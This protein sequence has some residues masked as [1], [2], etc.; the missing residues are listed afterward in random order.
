MNTYDDTD[1]QRLVKFI[2]I[3]ETSQ[4]YSLL[5]I[6]NESFQ[7]L[8]KLSSMGPAKLFFEILLVE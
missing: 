5:L 3:K 8:A 1:L 7:E 4:S 2:G 6:D